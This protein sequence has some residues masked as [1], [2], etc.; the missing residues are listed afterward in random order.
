MKIS[1]KIEKKKNEK[2]HFGNIWNPMMKNFDNFVDFSSKLS[3]NE[4]LNTNTRNKHISYDRSIREISMLFGQHAQYINISFLPLQ[5]YRNIHIHIDIFT[6]ISV[7]YL[8]IS[9]HIK[10][11]K[12]TT[13]KK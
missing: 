10:M 12:K 9:T 3:I 6:D 2:V 13:K 8:L 11:K 1:K 5:F 4:D 7:K